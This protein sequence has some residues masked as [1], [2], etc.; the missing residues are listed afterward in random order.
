MHCVSFQEGENYLQSHE[1]EVTKD[2]T[3]RIVAALIAFYFWETCDK[4]AFDQWTLLPEDTN[5]PLQIQ[6]KTNKAIQ[7]IRVL[8][9]DEKIPQ[10]NI[11]LKE[12][13]AIL[14]QTVKKKPTSNDVAYQ[15][16]TQSAKSFVG[17]WMA[18][19]QN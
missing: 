15:I 18:Q 19:K 9:D 1:F 16:L 12:A 13:S 5:N 4:E 2:T 3:P 8:Q 14:L 11:L 17:T 6:I 10:T 7:A